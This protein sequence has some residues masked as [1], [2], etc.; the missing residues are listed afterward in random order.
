MAATVSDADFSEYLDT[1]RRFTNEKLKPVELEIEDDG[2]IPEPIV[3]QMRE[4]KHAGMVLG[5][6]ILGINHRQL[7]L[8][9]HLLGGS[10]HTPNDDQW[11]KQCHGRHDQESHVAFRLLLIVQPKSS[12]VR[13]QL[14]PPVVSWSGTRIQ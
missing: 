5:D 6:L 11:Q 8:D 14:P 13:R 4:L 10:R 9:G 3:Q 12:L 7:P 1:I 2:K